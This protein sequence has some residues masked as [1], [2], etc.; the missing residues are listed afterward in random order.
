MKSQR[1]TQHEASVTA[2][3][4]IGEQHKRDTVKTRA[5]ERYDL[6]RE[7]PTKHAVLEG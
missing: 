5:R 6:S 7:R 3:Q 1:R 4:V 2:G